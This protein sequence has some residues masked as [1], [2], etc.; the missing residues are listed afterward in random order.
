MTRGKDAAAPV[1][2]EGEAP[3]SAEKTVL[4]VDDDADLR[5]LYR[6]ALERELPQCEVITAMDAEDA[7]EVLRG[8]PVDL[9]ITDQRMPGRTGSELI[10]YARAYQPGVL[11]I[12]VT[13][14]SDDARLLGPH[15]G[16]GVDRCYE[17]P[18]ALKLAA[19]AA[20]ELLQLRRP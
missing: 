14:F 11:C 16:I 4:V 12:L 3:A 5:G 1:Q 8:R 6:R 9:L 17:K 19:G 10:Q 20:R 7:L 13:G 18:F 2:G 15:R